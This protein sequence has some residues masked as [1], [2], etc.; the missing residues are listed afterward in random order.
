M[1]FQLKIRAWTMVEIRSPITLQYGNKTA[2]S[3][4]SLLLGYANLCIVYFKAV[5]ETLFSFVFFVWQCLFI[6]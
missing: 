3:K 2:K 4:V 6:G 1:N 5:E